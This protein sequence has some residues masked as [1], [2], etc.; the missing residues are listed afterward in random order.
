[1][2]STG[3]ESKVTEVAKVW[4]VGRYAPHTMGGDIVVNG[5]LVSTYTTAVHPV[6]AHVLLA[7]MRM[8]HRAGK[9]QWAEGLLDGGGEWIRT[10]MPRGRDVVQVS[11]WGMQA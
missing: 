6:L 10:I 8:L 9:A 2:L 11:R 3:R 7:P 5:V 4:G 1:M